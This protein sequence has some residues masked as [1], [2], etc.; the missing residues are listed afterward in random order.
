MLAVIGYHV[1]GA[2][3]PGGFLG[4]STFFT[5]SGFLITSLLI[6]E[7]D[8]TGRIN[9]LGFWSRRFRR[10]LPA[11]IAALGFVVIIGAAGGYGEAQ[12]QSVARA[13]PW[14]VGYLA[15]WQQLYRGGGYL[16]RLSAP[17][18]IKHFW[19]LAIEEQFYVVFPLLFWGLARALK[20]QRRFLLAGLG[21]LTTVVALLPRLTDSHERVYLGSDFRST[22]ILVGV[23]LA[24]LLQGR[25]ALPSS[26]RLRIVL[27]VAGPV[28]F[29]AQ[30]SAWIWIADDTRFLY[31]GGLSVYALLSGVLVLS[32]LVP[33]PW[34]SLA[35]W[36]PLRVVGLISYG[37]YLYH[38]PVL[39]WLDHS[40]VAVQL[41][42]A[43]AISV[44]SYF[45]LERP[46][47]RGVT[48]RRMVR[49]IVAAVAIAALVVT[50]QVTSAS[51]RRVDVAGVDH[52]GEV[53]P[54]AA[55]VMPT[56]VPLRIAL[57]TDG[58]PDLA[59]LVD[60]EGR[61]DG[62]W[63]VSAAV[64][65]QCPAEPCDWSTEWPTALAESDAVVVAADGWDYRPYAR[66]VGVAAETRTDRVMLMM[67]DRMML[68]VDLL[69]GNEARPVTWARWSNGVTPER[70]EI[71]DTAWLVF[72]T[73]TS[74]RPT[75][76]VAEL[77]SA[78]TN[79]L[80]E[81]VR[82]LARASRSDA[83]RVLVV[84]DSVAASLAAGLSGWGE[85]HNAVV[86]D[87]ARGGC[88]AIRRGNRRWIDGHVGP[89]D[90][91][92]PWRNDWADAVKRWRPDVVVLLVGIWDVADRQVQPGGPIVGPSDPA[93][94]SLFVDEYSA[95][96]KD[97]A[98]GGA[99]VVVMTPPCVGYGGERTPGGLG[100]KEPAFADHRQAEA[101]QLLSEALG[102][103]VFDLF[104]NLCPGGEFVE[105]RTDSGVEV[106]PDGSHF[107]HEGSRWWADRNAANVIGRA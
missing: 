60:A 103:A 61:R 102:G 88:G 14:V 81:K 7:H 28:A 44:A 69:E 93:W 66:S 8:R 72:R 12:N 32:C 27:A 94:R 57:V 16:A 30:V 34:S 51:A 23:M 1:S 18:P 58:R 45:G 29:A 80:I 67:L 39:R 21:L 77:G 95:A 33:G 85:T 56:P 35:A 59:A 5:L 76:R 50:G 101:R 52:N 38:W 25:F 74:R 104:D 41:V 106:R 70:Q 99:R 97:L 82:S 83:T 3:L 2:P 53:L 87:D 19:S 22:E 73:L 105:Q 91:C 90:D 78:D 54:D 55:P 13:M 84:G 20:R 63:L 62:G 71:A 64:S 92:L 65:L 68:A 42:V 43:V 96:V 15:N 26:A 47:R 107:S 4:V 48:Q 11:A 31:R 6:Q 89:E 37:L 36:R 79:L 40:P 100:P 10:L 75:M 17:S 24:V 98:S 49:P 9:L 46:I 86:W